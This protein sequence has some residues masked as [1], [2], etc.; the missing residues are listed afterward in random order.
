MITEYDEIRCVDKPEPGMLYTQALE[1]H[2]Y[3]KEAKPGT[4]EA[5]ITY[6]DGT[7]EQLDGSS[8]RVGTESFVLA[9]SGA[10]HTGNGT[11]KAMVRITYEPLDPGFQQMKV[12][13]CEGGDNP[14]TVPCLVYDRADGSLSFH[15]ED[16]RIE[17]ASGGRSWGILHDLRKWSAL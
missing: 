7:Q 5:V 3:A 4:V 11:G 15:G 8:H 14:P 9:Y 16:R 2:H 13:V 1:E 10:P 12:Y 17:V 6:P